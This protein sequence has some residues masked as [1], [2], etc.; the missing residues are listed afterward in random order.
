[1]QGEKY[2]AAGRIGVGSYF[3]GGEVPVDEAH[4]LVYVGVGFMERGED[5]FDPCDEF[6]V[7]S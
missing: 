5:V 3:P 1:M 6:R 7:V 4:C 2:Y